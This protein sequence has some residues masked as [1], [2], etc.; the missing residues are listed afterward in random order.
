[1]KSTYLER[2]KGMLLKKTLPTETGPALS[3]RQPEPLDV[4]A[5]PE[6]ISKYVQYPVGCLIFVKNLDPGTNK[7][8]LRSLLASPFQAE[9]PGCID[10][11]D[12]TKGLGSVGHG[13]GSIE[14]PTST[15]SE[16][17]PCPIV[18]AH[19]CEAPG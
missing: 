16:P 15:H 1:M 5:F 12:Y 4:T 2:Q 7:T 17:V 3:G 19:L 11:V 9:S 14:S 10:Y 13:L 18:F 6:T 8:V